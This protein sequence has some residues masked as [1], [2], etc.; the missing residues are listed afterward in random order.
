MKYLQSYELFETIFQ[1]LQFKGFNREDSKINSYDDFYKYQLK[2]N[3]YYITSEDFDFKKNTAFN[4][5][6]IIKNNIIK[7]FYQNYNS[8]NNFDIKQFFDSK[9]NLLCCISNS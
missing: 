4:G 6:Y 3:S 5:E 1:N 7:F 8:D 9:Y 2:L